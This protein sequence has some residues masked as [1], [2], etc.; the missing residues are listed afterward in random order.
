[1]QK[2]YGGNFTYISIAD[3]F[4]EYYYTPLPLDFI[5]DETTLR[6]TFET[7]SG[8][9][10]S[11]YIY[12]DGRYLIYQEGTYRTVY[13]LPSQLQNSN[14]YATGTP[15]NSEYIETAICSYLPEGSIIGSYETKKHGFQIVYSLEYM[16][17]NYEFCYLKWDY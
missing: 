7:S 5:P 14:Y 11:R 6:E 8:I 9:I 10:M 1:M 2:N 4:I 13:G 15:E 3:V 12:E 16:G 17:T